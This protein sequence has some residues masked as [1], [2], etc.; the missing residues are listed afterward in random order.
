MSFISTM[1]RQCRSALLIASIF[2]S[3]C[4]FSESASAATETTIYSFAN[5][6][7][8]NHPAYGVT[9]GPDG[10][11]YGTTPQGGADGGGV[12][13]GAIYQLTPPTKKHPS[14][15]EKVIYSFAGGS[16]GYAPQGPLVFDAAGNAYG[17]AENGGDMTSCHN[18]GCGLVYMLSPPAPGGKKWKYKVLHS[19]TGLDGQSPTGAVTLDSAGNLY[20]ATLYGGNDNYCTFDCGVI[21][22]LSTPPAGKVKWKE[23]VLYV[24]Q[25]DFGAVPN[26]GLIFNATQSALYGTTQGGG[27]NLL[28]GVVFAL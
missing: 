12:G 15:Q 19:F 23:E 10:N 21:F 22:K 28:D 9:Q 20:G 24:M 26:G 14:W 13:N 25:H 6:P 7:D 3:G 8:A 11:L 2:F 1:V 17:T 16:K 5:A 18:Q 4:V 27:T